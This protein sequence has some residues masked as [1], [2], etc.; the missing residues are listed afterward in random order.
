MNFFM[1]MAVFWVVTPC[2]LLEV[3]RRFRGACCLHHLGD[4]CVTDSLQLNDW[5]IIIKRSPITCAPSKALS[6]FLISH[7]HLA[8]ARSIWNV[9][10]TDYLDTRPT[11]SVKQTRLFICHLYGCICSVFS[12]Y[13]NLLFNINVTF[14]SLKL[15]EDNEVRIDYKQKVIF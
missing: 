12:F 2:S 7:C 10:P 14:I 9:F 1:E 8:A 4:R 6:N 11:S 13:W 3:Y 15:R 5:I